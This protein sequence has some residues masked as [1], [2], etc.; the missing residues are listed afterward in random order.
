MRDRD[1][2]GRD[3]RRGR[4][5]DP[6]VRRRT[7]PRAQ[8]GAGHRLHERRLRVRLPHLWRSHRDQGAVAR[9]RAGRE[10]VDRGPRGNGS[11]G[12]WRRGSGNDV[13]LRGARNGRAHAAPDHAR[14]RR[15]ATAREGTQGRN[16][17]VPAARREDPGHGGVREGRAEARA[18]GRRRGAARSGHR[19]SASLQ[20]D[21]RTGH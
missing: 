6:R 9:D 4:D 2:D 3:P 10:R 12:A 5:H 16:A 13:R 7:A 15:R 14:A 8:R 11:H 20:R 17:A 1:H 18:Y 19:L 21:S